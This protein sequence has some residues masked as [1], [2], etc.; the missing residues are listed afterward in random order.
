MSDS[1]IFRWKL[2]AV[3]AIIR[4]IEW[5][6]FKT[7][8][9]VLFL[10][11]YSRRRFKEFYPFDHPSLNVIPGSVDIVAYRPGVM[12]LNRSQCRER[13]GLPQDIPLLLTVRRLAAR[14]GLENLIT[15][16]VLLKRKNPDLKFYLVIV[17]KGDLFERLSS[18]ICE[19]GLED[20]VRLAGKITSE[21][22]HAYYER[23]ETK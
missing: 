15:A 3:A 18:Q 22:I 23:D 10:S 2:E 4:R 14:M 13:L 12:G 21:E 17:G 16:C 11:Q 19:T 1:W 20:C 7:A 6:C 8:K 5:L 9:K